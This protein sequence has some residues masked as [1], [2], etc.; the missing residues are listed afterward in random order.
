MTAQRR[1]GLARYN[2]TA[3][4]SLNESSDQVR[5]SAIAAGIDAI[6]VELIKLRISQING[7]AYCLRLHT[8]V[9]LDLGETVDRLS[10]LPAWRE[11][12]IFS[13]VER[14]SLELAEAVND[15]ASGVPD[16]IYDAVAQ[17]L[18]PEQIAAVS[19]VTIIIGAFNQIS[20]ASRNPVRPLVQ[21]PEPGQ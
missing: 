20:V 9:A 14:A 17:V 19:W 21:A 10:V 6:C 2:P 11:T 4:A 1:A 7:C 8:K 16:D 3:Y 12:A 5:D 13:D 15:I 18:S